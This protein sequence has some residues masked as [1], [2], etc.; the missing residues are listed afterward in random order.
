MKTRLIERASALALAA[1][2][3]FGLLAGINHLAVHEQASP[4]WA[5]AVGGDRA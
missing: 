4:V 1:F 2:V 5:C 3:T